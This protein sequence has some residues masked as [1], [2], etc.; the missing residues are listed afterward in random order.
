MKETKVKTNPLPFRRF[1]LIF[2]VASVVGLFGCG[3]VINQPQNSNNTSPPTVL[4]PQVG[5]SVCSLPAQVSWQ[6][7]G[8]TLT[9][10]H[11]T[12]DGVDQTS[13][14]SMSNNQ[15]VAT[16]K[17]GY[18]QHTL[19]VSGDIDSLGGFHSSATSQFNLIPWIQ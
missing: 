5:V 10:F 12:L 13:A 4:C 8:A 17:L 15:E 11:A 7:S 16:F 18:G 9:N 3:I 1:A 19:V 14:F 2:G 6:P